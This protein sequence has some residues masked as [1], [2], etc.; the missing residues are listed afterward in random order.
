M[1][2]QIAHAT[3]RPVI[4]QPINAFAV[5]PN[6]AADLAKPGLLYIGTLGNVK[7]TTV[8]GDTV[9]FV[10]LLE[11][12]T[13]PVSVKKVFSTDTTALNILLLS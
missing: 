2:S 4:F 11:G 8:G 3:G 7:V 6:D 10:G 1:S 13:L 12:T 5:T 9:T